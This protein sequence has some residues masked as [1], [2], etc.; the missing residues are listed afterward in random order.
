MMEARAVLISILVSVL[1]FCSFA[2]VIQ[3]ARAVVSIELEEFR[4]NRFPISVYVGL[5]QWSIPDY[6][7]AIREALDSWLK[8]IWNYTNAYGGQPLAMI[9][10]DYYVSNANST[11]NPDVIISFTSSVM[12]S[13]AVGL[14]TYDFDANS[15]QPIPPIIINITT[16]SGTASDLFVEDVT[17]HEFGHVLGVGHASSS[18]TENGPELMYYESSKRETVFPSTLD[19]YALTQLYQGVYNRTVQLPAGIPYVMLPEGSIPPPQTPPW[20][21]YLKYL[22]LIAVGVLFTLAIALIIA[23]ATTR[24]KT[25][26]SQLPPTLP[27]P[28]PESTPA[29]R[30]QQGYMRCLLG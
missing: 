22:P 18:N 10:Y 4:W 27:P 5:N 2:T 19:V 28:P 24:R 21:T 15:H 23:A 17:M 9:S 8:A 20:Q 30:V 12:N 11:R 14:T 7:V 1:L 6:A 3:P 16:Y 26:E 13:N 29:A 25:D